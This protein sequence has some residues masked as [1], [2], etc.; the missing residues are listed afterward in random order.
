MPTG[1]TGVPV[2]ARFGVPPGLRELLK[3]RCSD[4]LSQNQLRG[5]LGMNML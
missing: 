2:S 4:L 3:S 5:D 1:E